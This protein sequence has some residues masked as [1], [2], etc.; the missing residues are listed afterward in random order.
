MTTG[1]GP[2]ITVDDVTV[3]YGDRTVLDHVDFAISPGEIVSLIG[4]NGAGKSTLVRLMLGII[5]PRAGEVHRRLGAR[6]AYVPQKLQLDATLPLTVDRL[7]DL[8]RPHSPGMKADALAE[9]GG[10]SLSKSNVSSLSGGEFQRVLLARA[11]LLDPDLLVLDEPAQNVDFAGQADLFDL[12]AQVRDRRG[13]AVLLVSH[14]LHLVMAATDRVVCLNRHICCAGTPE[15][16]ASDPIYAT[17]FGARAAETLAVYRHRHDHAH[18]LSGK[19]IGPSEAER[20]SSDH[21]A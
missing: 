1:D 19:V 7:L 16:V 18:H 15:T 14:E 20:G 9:V 21:A 17:L 10:D 2:L 4:P 11:L 5:K 8:P 12:I 6:I 3:R 13:C